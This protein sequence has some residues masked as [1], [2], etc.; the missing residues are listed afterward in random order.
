MTLKEEL[1]ILRG[2][3]IEVFTGDPMDIPCVETSDPE[4]LCKHPLVSV[5]MITYNHE[6]YIRQAIE[7]VMMQKTDFEFELVIGEDCSQDKTREICFEYQKKYPDKVRVLWWHE[8]LRA[9]KHPAGGNGQRNRAH[10]RGD[11]IAHCEGDDYWIDPLKLQKQVDVMRRYPNVGL[12]Y[13]DVRDHFM[14]GAIGKQLIVSERLKMPKGVIPGMWFCRMA[15]LGRDLKRCEREWSGTP[16]PSVLT[17]R[18]I[19][20]EGDRRYEIFRWR[21]NLGDL[22][23]WISIAS[24][25][26]VYFLPEDCTRYHVTTTGALGTLR[27]RV[28]CDGVLVRLYFFNKLWGFSLKDYPPA[29][30]DDLIME[31]VKSFTDKKNF[32]ERSSYFGRLNFILSCL[33]NEGLRSIWFRPST[34]MW[35]GFCMINYL[36]HYPFALMRRL[37]PIVRAILFLRPKKELSHFCEEIPSPAGQV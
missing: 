5:H 24:L 34:A 25:S 1:E 12:C 17:R 18:G 36:G 13:T 22:Q 9:L 14:S 35:L 7:G 10:C 16:T 26:D 15:I 32:P 4:K 37:N 33:K 19:A 27:Q 31:F 2:E 20:E 23:R 3:P 8:N 30:C 21:L 28:H 29:A 11:F 6:P